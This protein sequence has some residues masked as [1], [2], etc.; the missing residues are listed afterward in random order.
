MKS[1][2]ACVVLGL[3]QH[4]LFAVGCEF[5]QRIAPVIHNIDK[6]I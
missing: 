1:V 3:Y 6:P 2:F 5:E 4:Q